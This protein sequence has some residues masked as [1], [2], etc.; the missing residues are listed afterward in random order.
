MSLASSAR[1]SSATSA[2]ARRIRDKC[3]MTDADIQNCLRGFARH[4]REK[5]GVIRLCELKEVMLTTLEEELRD[6]EVFEIMCEAKLDDEG[7]DHTLN[8]GEFLRL[9]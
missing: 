5:R 6:D 9:M 1:P 4:D 8:F 7:G 2:V 3:H